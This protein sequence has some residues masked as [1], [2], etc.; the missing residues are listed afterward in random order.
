MGTALH[1]VQGGVAKQAFLAKILADKT[2]DPEQ[3]RQILDS[4]DSLKA[5]VKQLGP[6]MQY[7]KLNK[8]D[9]AAQA[10]ATALLDK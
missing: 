1:K 9:K 8:G 5:N 7:A 6:A 4:I 2:E 3:K 10:K